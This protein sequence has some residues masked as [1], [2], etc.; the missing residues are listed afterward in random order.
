MHT[1]AE[2]PR[3]HLKDEICVAVNK[4][5]HF[6]MALSHL[7]TSETRH[8][9]DESV[10]GYKTSRAIAFSYVRTRVMENSAKTQ[11]VTTQVVPL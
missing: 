1:I 8:T 10:S 3:L 4:Y 7:L 2:I 5:K 11:K 9:S 6:S